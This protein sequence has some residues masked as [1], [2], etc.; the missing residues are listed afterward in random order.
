MAGYGVFSRYALWQLRQEDIPISAETFHVEL[1]RW[2]RTTIEQVLQSKQWEQVDVQPNFDESLDFDGDKVVSILNPQ[3]RHC[4]NSLSDAKN[5]LAVLSNNGLDQ[6]GNSSFLQAPESS[7]M[8]AGHKFIGLTVPVVA[9]KM[10][11]CRCIFHG[12]PMV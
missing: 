12:F 11:G 4:K 3:S 7:Q 8:V 6:E 2:T 10:G 9:G 5:V 1:L